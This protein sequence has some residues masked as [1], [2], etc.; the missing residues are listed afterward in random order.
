MEEKVS[1][2]TK[3][4]WILVLIPWISYIISSVANYG[5]GI[6]LPAMRAELH[7]GLAEAGYLSAIA[8]IIRLVTTIPITSLVTKIR[9]KTIYTGLFLCMGVGFVLQGI[10]TNL[11][12]VFV[13]RALAIGIMA[14]ISTILVPI[15]IKWIPEDKI[16]FINGIENMCGTGGQML[17]TVTVPIL[18]VALSGWRNIMLLMGVLSFILVIVW[19]GFVRDTKP[20]HPKVKETH[21]GETKSPLLEA[22]KLKQ[23][24]LLAIGWP[25]SIIA[26]ISIYTFWPTYAIESLGLTLAQ[27]GM[28]LGLLPIF[29]MIS[30]FIT[31][32]L[33][34]K[35]G[36]EKPFMWVCGIALPICYLSMINT[37]SIPLLCIASAAA[38]YFVYTYVPIGFSLLYKI[39]GIKSD[40]VSMGYSVVYTMLSIG[41]VLGGIVAGKL[42]SIFGLYFGMT[43]C[44]CAPLV[45]GICTFMLPEYGRKYRERLARENKT[46]STSEQA[47]A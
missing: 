17:G 12:M 16:T 36:Y 7:F 38:G 24:W 32:I 40:V 8:W 43:V 22:L 44:C 45:F 6:M 15:K 2:I 10:A 41:G 1:R 19:A 20:D 14:C 26:W 28:I 30:S 34:E 25:F 37:S 13:G 3:N 42:S 21:E 18:I 4:G 33:A 27:S 39:P 5:I 29:S 23:L 9:P 47:N 35:V 46:A 11:P 31:P